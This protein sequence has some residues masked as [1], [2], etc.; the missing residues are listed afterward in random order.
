MVVEVGDGGGGDDGFEAMQ[1]I[2]IPRPLHQR[3]SEAASQ[4]KLPAV[5]M[6]PC[7][8]APSPCLAW[9]RAIDTSKGAAKTG[10]SVAPKTGWTGVGGGEE[11]VVG[12]WW[13]WW[14]WW[15]CGPASCVR[16]APFW[17]SRRGPSFAMRIKVP[18]ASRG[19]AS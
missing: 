14:P 6:P 12:V 4:L 1:Q 17:Q 15:P 9:V 2:H 10:T 7:P 19:P 16:R 5:R 13:P 11:G 18:E 3:V 8:P